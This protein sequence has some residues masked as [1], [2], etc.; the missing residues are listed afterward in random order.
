[1]KKFGVEKTMIGIAKPADTFAGKLPTTV[2]CMSSSRTL[3]LIRSRNLNINNLI[4]SEIEKLIKEEKEKLLAKAKK[5]YPIGTKFKSLIRENR[6]WVIKQDK[7]N[8]NEYGVWTGGSGGGF[9]VFNLKEN[10]WAEIISK[11]KEIGETFTKF[12]EGKPSFSMIPQKA[13]LEVAKVM[14]YGKSKYTAF[15]YSKEGE[16]LRYLDALQRH[17]NQFLC[18]EDIDSE[19]NT[20]HLANLVANGLMALDGI[21]NNT[22]IDN[23]NKAYKK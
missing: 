17:L 15:N 16:L 20:N 21:L 14:D 8:L 11:P 5:N 22:I 9:L 3:N 6:Y 7:F 2:E 18:G 10:K 12:D 19:T 1:M 13:L 4:M 23:R